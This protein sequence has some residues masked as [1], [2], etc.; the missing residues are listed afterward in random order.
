MSV[1]DLRFESFVRDGLQA[2]V[3][4]TVDGR[5][6]PVVAVE[7]G[8]SGVRVR[9][10]LTLLGLR[11]ADPEVMRP[12]VRHPEPDA[13]GVSPAEFVF[14]EYEIDS[15]PWALTPEPPT[16][17]DRST[18]RPWV[19]LVVIPLNAAGFE[20]RSV[21]AFTVWDL[22][23]GAVAAQLPV[24]G[25]G[26]HLWAHALS[27]VGDGDTDDGRRVSRLVCP[28]LL[29]ADTDYVAGVVPLRRLVTEALLGTAGD[30]P[31]TAPGEPAWR[32]GRPAELVVF[33]TW[34]FRTGPVGDFESLVD[35]LTVSA[36]S[37]STGQVRVATTGGVV[38]VSG[39]LAGIHS[40]DGSTPQ[41]FVDE[42]ADDASSQ[43]L[44]PRY[45]IGFVG[46]GESPRWFR[47]LNETVGGRLAASL[48]ARAAQKVVDAL[49]SEIQ[50]V[51]PIIFDHNNADFISAGGKIGGAA[52]LVE[53]GLGG[54]WRPPFDPI[55]AGPAIPGGDPSVPGEPIGRPGGLGQLRSVN[56]A[57]EL[58][59][60]LGVDPGSGFEAE[61]SERG[62]RSLESLAVL[63]RR[64]EGADHPATD[65]AEIPELFDSLASVQTILQGRGEA[66]G[67]V[68]EAEAGPGDA[69][70]SDTSSTNDDSVPGPVGVDVVSMVE[71]A[72]RKRVQGLP[73]GWSGARRGI[74]TSLDGTGDQ[75]LT[76]PEF[77]LPG[78]GEVPM[79]SITPLRTNGAFSAAFLV[80]FN[81]EINRTLTWRGW[82]IDTSNTVLERFW[83]GPGTRIADWA[84]DE[85]LSVVAGVDT[86]LFAVLIRSELVARFPHLSVS[87]VPSRFD[88]ERVVIDPDFGGLLWPRFSR[89]LDAHTLFAVFDETAEVMTASS[90]PPWF[91]IIEE[92]AASHRYGVDYT[93]DGAPGTPAEL[94]RWSDLH[95]GLL[96]GGPYV[97]VDS[98]PSDREVEGRTF[99]ATSS[100]FAA[101]LTQKRFRQFYPLAQLAS[102]DGQS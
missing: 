95:R 72:Y 43:G 96:S 90:G 52:E 81:H 67:A 86:E 3:D 98:F 97:G 13:V 77:V 26:D 37:V 19:G 36:G 15:L 61:L 46:D 5:G 75:R 35:K 1:D 99:A 85:P 101:N 45:G 22:S 18:L 14:V 42:V 39:A 69:V 41:A 30:D 53:M 89:T 21:G 50:A 51:L 6:R 33:D 16:G 73:G 23:P 4:G 9:R 44:L 80:G 47:E 32:P 74:R 79:N 88:G 68:V 93:S 78:V 65:F 48:G 60:V 31:R 38:P 10:E 58:L 91:L 70:G 71:D 7:V 64:L 66:S 25:E 28:R 29:E 55:V 63:G 20:Q 83:P 17:L 56:T 57:V 92:T 27:E 82:P 34:R 84:A 62:V 49:E 94:S 76:E 59:R 24:V 12:S 102:V 40:V 87:A 8:S 11:D 54:W 2:L 100:G